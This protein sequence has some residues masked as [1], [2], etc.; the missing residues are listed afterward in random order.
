M[1]F[2]KGG[3]Y[4]EHRTGQTIIEW[5][6]RRHKFGGWDDQAQRF[7]TSRQRQEQAA[8]PGV[9]QVAPY[10][11]MMETEVSEYTLQAQKMQV[12]KDS[13]EHGSQVQHVV[14]CLC[15]Q[16]TSLRNR[17]EPLEQTSGEDWGIKTHER[18]ETRHFVRLSPAKKKTFELVSQRQSENISEST[19]SVFLDVSDQLESESSDITESRSE[20]SSWSSTKFWSGS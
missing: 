3:Q 7:Q 20:F 10:F 15:K 8:Q 2:E 19:L 9:V 17:H 11:Q 5:P 6:Q 18:K 1:V 12:A 13:L 4:H 14:A 16:L